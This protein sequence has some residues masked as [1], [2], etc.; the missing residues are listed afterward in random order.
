MNSDDTL[1]E[2]MMIDLQFSYIICKLDLVSVSTQ[3][4]FKCKVKSVNYMYGRYLT[5]IVLYRERVP[6]RVT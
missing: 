5:K 6:Y 3:G 1:D 4:S 2:D